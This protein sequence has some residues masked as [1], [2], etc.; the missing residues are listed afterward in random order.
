MCFCCQCLRAESDRLMSQKC[1]FVNYV[2]A[3]PFSGLS[4]A[5][6]PPGVEPGNVAEIQVWQ[7]AYAFYF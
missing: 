1:K 2:A 5:S 3:Y 6:V 7:D 4:Q